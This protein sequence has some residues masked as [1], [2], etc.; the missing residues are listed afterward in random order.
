MQYG[1]G[2]K[3]LESY[4]K[5]PRILRAQK[6]AISILCVLQGLTAHTALDTILL[7]LQTDLMSLFRDT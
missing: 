4:S 6:S 1:H 7:G 5:Q 3:I 2:H